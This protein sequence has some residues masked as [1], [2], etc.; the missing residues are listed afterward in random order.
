MTTTATQ[1]THGFFSDLVL[2]STSRLSRMSAVGGTSAIVLTGSTELSARNR[3]SRAWPDR[4]TTAGRAWSRATHT[5]ASVPRATPTTTALQKWTSARASRV[6]TV[7]TVKIVL[8]SVM[9][10]TVPASTRDLASSNSDRKYRPRR[11]CTW[12]S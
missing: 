6:R 11:N 1:K 7:S 4:A 2:M 9:S 12:Q 10:V 5:T 8:L 3:P